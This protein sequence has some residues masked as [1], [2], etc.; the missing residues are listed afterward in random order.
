MLCGGTCDGQGA[1]AYAPALKSCRSAGC[2]TDL[3]QITL[4]ATCDGAG[5]CPAPED[6]T[7]NCNGFGCYLENGASLCKTDCRTDPDC[8]IRRYCEVTPADAET[9]DG[10]SASS[11]PSQFPLGRAC[12]RDTQCLSMNC[13]IPIG[14][15]VGV[16]CN[17]D[18]SHCGTC[19]STGTC[20]PDPAGTLSATCADSASDPSRKC[21]GMCDGHAHCQYPSAGTN[22]GTA[23]APCKACNGV[24]LCNL[25]PE[26]DSACGV[27]DCDVLN[28]IC[29]EYE[30]LTTKRCGVIGVCKASNTTAS[31]T[32]FT[33]SCTG[34][35]GSSGTGTGGRG[36]AGGGGGGSSGGGGGGST[37]TAGS[38][39]GSAA[40]GGTTGTAGS[41]TGRGGA[42]GT[43]GGA[44]AGTAGGGGGGCCSVGGADTPTGVVGL[45][46]FASVLL[47]RRRRR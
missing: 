13:A 44:T 9:A 46:V 37:G 38:T 11:C 45:L 19:D 29:L 33:N 40:R 14:G 35:G 7:R 4:A 30:D 23:S 39:G 31:C 10:G 1:C 32:I 24:G 34:T 22:C 5:N 21:G 8:A 42:T 41:T 20:I 3:G 12:T 26:D 28:T 36:G 47:T 15:T 18:C 43:D 17:T 2:Q 16:C 25:M 27:I 6:P